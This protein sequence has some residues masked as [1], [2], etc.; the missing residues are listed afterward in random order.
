MISPDEYLERIVAGIHSVTTAGAEV[1]WNESINGRQFDVIIRFTVGT[2]SYLV[3]VE[4]KNKTRPASATDVEAF[5]VK[6]RDHG[7]NKSVFVTAAGFQSGAVKVAKRHGVDLFTVTFDETQVAPSKT[8]SFLLLTKKGAQETP[9]WKLEEPSLVNQIEEI[10]LV[11]ADGR[12]FKF[13]DEPSQ[14]TY[15]AG[16]SRLSDGRSLHELVN[17]LPI[18]NAALDERNIVSFVLDNLTIR[19][20]DD[21]FFPSGHLASLELNVK[22]RMGRQITGNVRFDP[23]ILQSPVIYTNAI[24]GESSRFSLASLPLGMQ[25]VEVGKF[26]FIVHPLIYY[27]CDGI[28]GRSVTWSI[29]ESFQNGEL[30]Q[31]VMTQDIAWSPHYIP[32]ND[33]VIVSRLNARLKD[34]R[35]RG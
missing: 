34:L 18:T 32:V 19:P 14:A 11:Y 23:A 4:V 25:R 21:F 26:Y 8:M 30:I 29:V 17:T 6:A 28:S 33:K 10:T 24:T 9:Q 31:A 2:L 27:H 15:Y 5:T 3:L 22:T 12:V 1:R 7:A 35:N 13:P 16:K 20:P